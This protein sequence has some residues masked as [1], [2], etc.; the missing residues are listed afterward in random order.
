MYYIAIVLQWIHVGLGIA[1]FGTVLYQDF[2]L[3][4]VLARLEVGTRAQFMAAF[5]PRF[6][7]SIAALAGLTILSG[8]VRGLVLGLQVPSTYF[9]TYAAAIVVG[10]FLAGFGARVLTPATEPAL[11]GN[12][13]ALERLRR[14]LVIEL[15]AFLV[16]FTL[17]IAMRF[18]Y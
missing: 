7:R 16:I 17:M 1:W 10:I 12:L 6:R 3:F 4:P 15:S 5:W 8:I 13:E 11:D 9:F 18:G 14:L 2:M